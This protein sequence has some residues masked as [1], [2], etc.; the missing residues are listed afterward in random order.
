ML[1]AI[2]QT[3]REAR[4]KENSSISIRCIIR[5]NT[6]PHKHTPIKYSFSTLV[7]QAQKRDVEIC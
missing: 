6:Q 3:N 5:E 7:V 2:L 4:N 1:Y